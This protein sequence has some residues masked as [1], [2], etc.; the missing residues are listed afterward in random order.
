MLP[1]IRFRLILAGEAED[2]GGA[3]PGFLLASGEELIEDS[4]E[5]LLLGDWKCFLAV[6]GEETREGA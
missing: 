4:V 6:E 2:G 3:I 5:G 1:L